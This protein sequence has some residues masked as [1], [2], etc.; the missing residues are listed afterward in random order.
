MHAQTHACTYKRTNARAHALALVSA[1]TSPAG[2]AVASAPPP[3]H[4]RQ[5]E[6]AAPSKGD[7]ALRPARRSVSRVQTRLL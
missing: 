4:L 3:R 6:A 7:F 5:L 2:G 1:G